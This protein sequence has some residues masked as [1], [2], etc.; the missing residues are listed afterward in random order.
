MISNAFS[1]T[2]SFF[3]FFFEKL[4]LTVHKRDVCKIKVYV[5]FHEE[6]GMEKLLRQEVSVGMVNKAILNQKIRRNGRH[7]CFI[8]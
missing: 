8:V 5:W 1:F 7:P 6:A 4:E 2:F 3:L